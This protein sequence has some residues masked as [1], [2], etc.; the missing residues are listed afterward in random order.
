MSKKQG[1][2]VV[3]AGQVKLRIDLEEGAIGRRSIVPSLK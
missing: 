3:D 1:F 2:Q